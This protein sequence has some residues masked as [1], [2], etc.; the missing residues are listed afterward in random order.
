MG[1][2]YHDGLLCYRQAS[3]EED[4]TGQLIVLFLV[5]G[6]KTAVPCP[7]LSLILGWHW[8][9]LHD[10]TTGYLSDIMQNIKDILM[11]PDCQG[12]CLT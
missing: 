2:L 3:L 4:C 7:H 11:I 1:L 5:V 10:A 9:D 6:R 8:L 12:S